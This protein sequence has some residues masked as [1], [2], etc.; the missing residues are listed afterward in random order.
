MNK[1]QDCSK[2]NKKVEKKIWK[3]SNKNF[4]VNQ[5]WFGHKSEMVRF[6][7]EKM[8]KENMK[9]KLKKK[10]IHFDKKNYEK[11]EQKERN[12]FKKIWKKSEKI[13]T[14]EKIILP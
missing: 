5:K 8:G 11:N 1:N 6:E 4:L 7:H 3:K 9:K 14:P 2:E 10:E 12:S 13:I